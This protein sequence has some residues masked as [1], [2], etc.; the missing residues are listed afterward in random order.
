MTPSLVIAA[1]E[2]MEVWSDQ[3]AVLVVRTEED[4]E[5]LR[6]QE[7]LLD[8][9]FLASQ[10]AP[11]GR[12]ALVHPRGTAAEEEVVTTAEEAQTEQEEGEGPATP[13]L[14]LLATACGPAMG[15]V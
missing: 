6:V 7:V 10:L 11:W 5:G 4:W 1:M 14:R 15:S 9:L 13:P 3:R 12:A 2:A 8:T